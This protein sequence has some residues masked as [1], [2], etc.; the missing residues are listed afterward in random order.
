MNA[1]V[2]LDA[3]G[4]PITRARRDSMKVGAYGDT[5]HNGA[6]MGRELR[7]FFPGN[8]SANSDISPEIDVIT[9]R[10]RDLLRNDPSAIAPVMSA[11]NAI[12]GPGLTF[13]PAPN[14]RA[15]GKDQEWA[16]EWSDEVHS[17]LEPWFSSSE[18]DASGYGN[19]DRLTHQVLTAV[20]MNGGAMV[21]PVWLPDKGLSEWGTALHV[22]EID[23]LRNPQD[24]MD[25]LTMSGGVETDEYGR[26]LAYHI[27]TNHPGDLGTIGAVP[28]WERVPAWT[29]WSVRPRAMHVYD[30]GRAGQNRGLS[31]L[32]PV[33]PHLHMLGRAD[34]AELESALANALIAFF[35]KFD[36]PPEMLRELFQDPDLLNE[37]RTGRN[38][39]FAHGGQPSS[40][41]VIPLAPNESVE[42]HRSDRPNP[43]WAPFS[44]GILRRV[45]GAFEQAF[46]IGSKNLGSLNY[47]ARARP[48]W[49]PGGP[50]RRIARGSSTACASPPTGSR[51]RRRSTAAGS[52]TAP[53]RNSTATSLPGRTATGTDRARAT[54]TPSRRPRAARCASPACAPPSATSAPTRV[55]IGVMCSAS[56]RPSAPSAPST[57]S[58]TPRRRRAA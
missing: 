26:P 36:L 34:Q 11:A 21:L 18:C 17:I 55:S 44:E 25:T 6:S 2:I 45:Y 7:R 20:M 10:S 31:M 15:L 50:G 32:A 43:N 22:V 9:A 38:L 47:S 29:E 5:K 40:A 57:A 8:G 56:R 23:R 1:P 48:A 53:L 39:S 41:K 24:C 28:Q 42:A 27:M 37:F 49:R 13:Q 35:T 51:S 33:I 14:W 58:R 30:K 12:V 54:S 46:E 19:F 4:V 52:A 3:A 16:D